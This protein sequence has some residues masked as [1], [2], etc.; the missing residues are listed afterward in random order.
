MPIPTKHDRGA[1]ERKV[2]SKLLVD[3]TDIMAN[4]GE[5]VDKVIKVFRIE[6]PSGRIIFEN[7]NELS[8]PKRIAAVLLGKY[9]GHRLELIQEDSLGISEIANELGRPVTA[10][11]GPIAGLVEEGLVTRLPIRKYRVVYHRIPAIIDLLTER[12]KNEPLTIEDVLGRKG[13]KRG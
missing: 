12:R 3:E 11:S 10:L 5:Q 13:A 7:F 2:L 1:D 8:D 9:F 6:N 4:L